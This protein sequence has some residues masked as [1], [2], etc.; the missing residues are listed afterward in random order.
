MS[1]IDLVCIEDDE[2]FRDSLLQLNIQGISVFAFDSIKS[3]RSKI[4]ENSILLVDYV[5]EQES[6]L[7]IFN[8]IDGLLVKPPVI[9]MT[10]F[11]D[12]SMAITAANEGVYKI[13]EKPLSLIDLTINIEEA[14]WELEKPGL[15][16][17]RTSKLGAQASPSR[18]MDHC[19]IDFLSSQ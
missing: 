11:A 8:I 13:L 2:S 15:R 3:A 19:Q 9:F 16:I 1:R 6:G 4:S 5:L 17:A 7:E 14:I 12:T 18:T 10:A